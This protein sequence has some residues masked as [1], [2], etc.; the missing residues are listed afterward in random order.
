MEK[1]T[2]QRKVSPTGSWIR[3]RIGKDPKIFLA[4]PD[5]DPKLEVLDSDSDPKI[6]VLDSDPNPKQEMHIT[7]NHLKFIETSW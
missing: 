3:I 4:D 6:E 1:H 2:L 7:K 5:T